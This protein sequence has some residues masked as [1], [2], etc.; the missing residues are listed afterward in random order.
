MNCAF[1]LQNRCNLK[2]HAFQTFISVTCIWET[3]PIIHSV[4]L[5][6]TMCLVLFVT[7]HSYDASIQLLP[8]FYRKVKWLV[9]YLV[10]S[11]VSQCPCDIIKAP[12]AVLQKGED[13]AQL[14]RVGL[15]FARQCDS[16]T[17][18]W[19]T[20]PV[21]GTLAWRLWHRGQSLPHSR[22]ATHLL[23]KWGGCPFT[24]YSDGPSQ[25]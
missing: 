6:P 18:L 8:Q 13:I 19:T 15:W 12:P 1:K 3:W 10:R 2:L 14:G 22:P 17:S 23:K 9:C 16:G 21:P 25:F 11:R 7:Q 4:L 20:T 24:S 5:P